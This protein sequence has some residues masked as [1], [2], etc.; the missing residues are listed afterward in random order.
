MTGNTAPAPTYGVINNDTSAYLYPNNFTRIEAYIYPYLNYTSL[1]R[2]SGDPEYAI[3]YTFPEGGYDNSPQPFLPAGS[4]VSPGGNEALY[5]VLFTVTAN[6]KN[7]GKVV[8]DEVPQ[9]YVSL[10]GPNDPKVVLRK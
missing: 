5:D 4:R 2:S 9:L 3:N 1:S 10:G 6:I 8:G 7:T